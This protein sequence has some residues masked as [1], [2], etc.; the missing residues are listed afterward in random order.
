MGEG[1]PAQEVRRRHGALP[2]DPLGGVGEV[3]VAEPV[4]QRVV[5]DLVVVAEVG[6]DLAAAQPTG[7]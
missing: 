5:A 7:D 2:L 6:L 3:V 1:F 4:V